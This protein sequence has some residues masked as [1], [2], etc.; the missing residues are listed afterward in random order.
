LAGFPA[1]EITN[2]SKLQHQTRPIEKKMNELGYTMVW[3]H[4]LEYIAPPGFVIEIIHIKSH[5]SFEEYGY[6]YNSEFHKTTE[7]V[8]YDMKYVL[9]L[10]RKK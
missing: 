5:K 1:E 9:T 6:D 4:D 2:I 10:L 3:S 8:T 7:D